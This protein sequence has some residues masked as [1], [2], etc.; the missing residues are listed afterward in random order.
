[1]TA[2]TAS[3]NGHSFDCS[4]GQLR[5]LFALNFQPNNSTIYLMH[6]VGFLVDRYYQN[7]LMASLYAQMGEEVDAA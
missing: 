7:S 2:C 3:T 4:I 5:R 6:K 1:M